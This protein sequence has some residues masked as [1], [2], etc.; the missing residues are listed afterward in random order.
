[1][2]IEE[3]LGASK[4]TKQ[5][6]PAWVS[7]VYK[8]VKSAEGEYTVHAQQCLGKMKAAMPPFGPFPEVPLDKV[9]EWFKDEECNLPVETGTVK[10]NPQGKITWCGGFGGTVTYNNVKTSKKMSEIWGA[11]GDDTD[12]GF[13]ALYTAWG[14]APMAAAPMAA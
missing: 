2:S 9:P 4:I 7:K 8:V 11:K 12:V 1:M 13:G 14:V 10:I 6:F 3:F 5:A